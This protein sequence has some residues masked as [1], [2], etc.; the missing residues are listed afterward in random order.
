ML[1]HVGLDRISWLRRNQLV[2]FLEVIPG[3][4][5]SGAPFLHDHVHGVMKSVPEQ[6]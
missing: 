2:P 3:Q 4:R 6:L 1:E 5:G